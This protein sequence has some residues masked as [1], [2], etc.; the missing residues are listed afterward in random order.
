[1]GPSKRRGQR[2]TA[3]IHLVIANARPHAEARSA[4]S[5][6]ADV[7]F[8][9]WTWDTTEQRWLTRCGY[10]FAPASDHDHTGKVLPFPFCPYCGAQIRKPNAGG[11]ARP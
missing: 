2:I 7:R 3:S 6:Q 9:S 5:V 8:C 11:E 4:D 1:M 10:G